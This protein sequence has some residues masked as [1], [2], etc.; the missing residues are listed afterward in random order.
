M[1]QENA[2]SDSI[3]RCNMCAKQ[4]KAVSGTYQEDFIEGYKEWG[5]F[6][7]KDLEIHKFNICE[8]CYGELIQSFQ[9]PVEI[10]E[11]IEVL[12]PSR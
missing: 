10:S 12:Y 2:K 4:I 9:I 8:D 6:S 1:R 7:N 5:Y 11:K 3:I